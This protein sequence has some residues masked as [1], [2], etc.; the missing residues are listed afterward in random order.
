MIMMLIW[1]IILIIIGIWKW[2]WE[3]LQYMNWLEFPTVNRNVIFE[4]YYW[5]EFFWNAWWDDS[6]VGG[7]GIDRNIP[8]RMNLYKKKKTN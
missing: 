3:P 4:E 1:I 5:M 7:I 6:C 2:Q 8:I